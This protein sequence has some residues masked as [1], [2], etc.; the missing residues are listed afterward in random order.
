MN[1]YFVLAYN[2]ATIVKQCK[3]CT[4]L[5]LIFT[6]NIIHVFEIRLVHE[7]QISTLFP[8]IFPQLAI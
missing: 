4:K 6:N 3:H 8:K 2:R 7:N 1:E 5:E